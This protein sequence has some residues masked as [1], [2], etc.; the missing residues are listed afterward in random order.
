MTSV[1]TA[2]SLRVLLF[3]RYAEL[4]GTPEVRVTLPA[5][6]TVAD[7]VRAVRALPGGGGLPDQLFCAI[8]LEQ[9]TP[10]TPLRATDELALLP[11]VAG[12]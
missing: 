3:A 11:P 8:N 12:G 9:V 4:L 6:S 7:A 1:E 10:E 5:R 2:I